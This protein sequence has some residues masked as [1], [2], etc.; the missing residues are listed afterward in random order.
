MKPTIVR[1]E[2]FSLVGFEKYTYDGAASIH[3]AWDAFMSRSDEIPN[4]VHSAGTYGYEDYSRD[5]VLGTGTGDMPKFYYMAGKEVTSLADIPEGMSGKKV[6]AATYAVFRHEGP[7][8]AMGRLYRHIYDK[9]LP[10]SGYDIDPNVCGDFEHYPLP[11]TDPENAVVDIYLPLVPAVG[12]RERVER[13]TLPDLKA[14]VIASPCNGYG[15]REAW[16][17]LKALAGQDP[18]FGE[19]KEGVVLIPEWQWASGVERLWTGVFVDSFEGLP[20][21]IERLTIPSR[22][23]ARLRVQGD[24]TKMEEGYAFLEEWFQVSGLERDQADGTFGFEINPITPIN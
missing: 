7:L 21:G 16:A 12:H 6:P 18:R 3:E 9:W 2:A 5:F 11:V 14:A 24:R 23:Y 20:D 13:V 19:A 22:S 17:A 1:K 15:T 10:Q 8:A 4:V